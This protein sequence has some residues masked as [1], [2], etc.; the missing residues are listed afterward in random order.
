MSISRRVLQ[1][2]EKWFSKDG[3]RPLNYDSETGELVF[4][5]GSEK[6]LVKVL[7]E[8]EVDKD[9]LVYALTSVVAKASEYNMVYIAA[10]TRMRRENVDTAPF[11][12]AGVGLILYDEYDVYEE[13]PAESR[14]NKISSKQGRQPVEVQLI[15]KS[16]I[17]IDSSIRELSE[18]LDSLE[19]AYFS[20]LREVREVKSLMERRMIVAEKPVQQSSTKLEEPVEAEGLPSFLKDN[21]WVEILSK[22]SEESS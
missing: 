2:V 14:V 22:R 20:L 4:S 12:K 9:T 19:K 7:F 5:K 13:V 6:V 18:R 11:M 8:D 1:R 17:R 21:P 15:E 16:L 10:P 3:L